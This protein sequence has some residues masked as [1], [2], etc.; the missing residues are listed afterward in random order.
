ML[1]RTR[2]AKEEGLDVEKRGLAKKILLTIGQ[3]LVFVE[4]V[5]EL[6]KV[7]ADFTEVVESEEDDADS[8]ET[9]K[10]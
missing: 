8:L 10:D 5:Q 7:R 4:D 2:T 6:D 9:A 1:L 3:F